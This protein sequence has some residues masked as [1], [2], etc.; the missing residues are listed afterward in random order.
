MAIHIC[1]RPAGK[2]N[3]RWS[4]RSGGNANLNTFAINTDLF[5]WS[6]GSLIFVAWL[7]CAGV[8]RGSDRLM[9]A[10]GLAVFGAYFFYY[11][12]GGPDFG[13][14]NWFSVMVVPLVA[15]TVRGIHAMERE[16]GSRVWV[17]VAALTT[18]SLVNFVPWRA[19]D[20]YY[21]YRGMRADVRQ[22]AAQ[23]QFGDDLILV[24]GERFPDYA[25]AFVENPIDL[26][27]RTTIYAWDRNA[28]L[29][30]DVLRAYLGRR[31]W[32][33]D[34]PSLTGS[35]YRV[36]QGPVDAAVLLAGHLSK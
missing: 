12:A 28:D 4:S 18:M 10:A 5:G 22:L 36:V 2:I 9:A 7:L 6:T 32:F 24:R 27:S 34:G 8:P 13:A 33:V 11:F 15:L 3:Q 23:Y 20:K 31:V 30:A 26:T 17:A 25:S 14:R 19:V 35:G 1:T 16:A 29:R 21:H